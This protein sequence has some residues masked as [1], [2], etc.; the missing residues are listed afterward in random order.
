MTDFSMRKDPVVPFTG[1]GQVTKK[2]H[3]VVSS[4]ASGPS[5]VIPNGYL[6]I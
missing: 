6:T 2:A 1:V 5:I 3:W 4:V